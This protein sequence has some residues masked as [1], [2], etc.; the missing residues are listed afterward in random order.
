MVRVWA[1]FADVKRQMLSSKN[2]VLQGL[3]GV[4]V[5]IYACMKGAKQILNQRKRRFNYSNS[6]QLKPQH[7]VEYCSISA[8]CS[9]SATAINAN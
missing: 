2:N 3:L 4:G 6:V 1:Q 8:A 7:I 5:Q 9:S